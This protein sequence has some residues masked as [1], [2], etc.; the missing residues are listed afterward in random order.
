M[1]LEIHSSLIYVSVDLVGGQEKARQILAK[2]MELGDLAS[3]SSVYKRYMS[4]E[5]VD[6]SARMEFVVRFD[7]VMSVDQTLFMLLSLQEH[8]AAVDKRRSH[9]E[10]ILLAFD[11]KTVM[12]PKMTLPY[13]YLHTDALAIRCAAE[14]W[15]S[16][17]HPIYQKT[18]SEI[19]KTAEPSRDAEFHL[20]GK[21][22]VD[23]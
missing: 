18:L 8:H 14:A 11:Q 15:G 3:I 4:R 5:R 23:F 12:S 19:A 9:C 7:T 10:L 1:S 17:E 2:F 20:Q 16:Y 13:P 21:S 22:L 6:F